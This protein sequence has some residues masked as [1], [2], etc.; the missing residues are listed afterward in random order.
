[1]HVFNTHPGQKYKRRT[2]FSERFGHAEAGAFWTA[3]FDVEYCDVKALFTSQEIKRFR[4]ACCTYNL[5]RSRAFEDLLDV[6]C[7]QELI[8]EY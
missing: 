8:V 6:E 2:F 7:D 5:C 1:M 4:R 3:K